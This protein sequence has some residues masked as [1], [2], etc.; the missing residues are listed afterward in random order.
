MCFN[1]KAIQHEV[2]R[3]AA[4]VVGKAIKSGID[5]LKQQGKEGLFA[6]VIAG[7][8]TH[9]GQ[10]FDTG[11]SLGYHALTNRGFSK[12]DPPHDMDGELEKTVQEFITLWT[13]GLAD[14]GITPNRIYAHTAFLS[15]RIFKANQP[16]TVSYSQHNHLA[17]PSVAFGKSHRPRKASSSAG[18]RTPNPRRFDNGLFQSTSAPPRSGND[19]SPNRS[20]A[21]ASPI[22]GNPPADRIRAGDRKDHSTGRRRRAAVHSERGSVQRRP[23]ECGGPL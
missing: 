18:S 9:I 7:G 4:D 14:A 23:K 1:S 22:S 20:C 19:L 3:R 21:R 5:G 17:T 6:G 2:R 11:R 10:D 8:E 16:Q 15:K 13:Q 12:T